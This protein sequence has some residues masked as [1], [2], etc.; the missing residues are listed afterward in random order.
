MVVLHDLNLAA[1]Y[2]TSLVLLHN[3]QVVA[4]GSPDDV[5]TPETMQQV[6]GMRV[7]RVY[8]SGALQLIFSPTDETAA[9]TPQD[10]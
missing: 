7:E 4:T 5:L 3:G 10:A 9:H 6:Y 1:R 2:C 8:V